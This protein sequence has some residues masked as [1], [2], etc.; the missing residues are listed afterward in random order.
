MTLAKK[1]KV[2]LIAE[3]KKLQR[4]IRSFEKSQTAEN[5]NPYSLL[6]NVKWQSFF[7]KSQN[8]TVVVDR[9]GIILDMNSETKQVK[10]KDLI[11]K[12]AFSIVSGADL[13]RMKLAIEKVFKTKKAT[14]FLV[15]L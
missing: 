11:G 9:K 10:K 7:R 8:I 6:S 3:L 4:K 15:S 13:K 14:L 2:E 1:S 12:S 5:T